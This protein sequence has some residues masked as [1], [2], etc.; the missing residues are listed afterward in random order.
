[1]TGN[2]N[3]L[4]CVAV[5]CSVLQ[6]NKYMRGGIRERRDDNFCMSCRAHES[7][8]SPICMSHGT[9]MNES[10]HTGNGVCGKLPALDSVCII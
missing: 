9:D 10:W 7:F 5:C 4:Q 3:I 2:K 8:I 6:W 1:V